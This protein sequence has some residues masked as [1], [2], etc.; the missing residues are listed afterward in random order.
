[1]VRFNLAICIEGVADEEVVAER[2]EK[3]HR[4]NARMRCSVFIRQ[5]A[6][7]RNRIFFP[8]TNDCV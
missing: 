1:M 4:K 6:R 7:N 8:I 3:S 2:F 5:L